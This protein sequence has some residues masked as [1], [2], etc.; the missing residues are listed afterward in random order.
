MMPTS[1]PDG[2]PEINEKL[3]AVKKSTASMGDFDE[4]VKGENK[5][6]IAKKRKVG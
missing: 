4:K 2:K 6:K 3:V 5:I 1:K